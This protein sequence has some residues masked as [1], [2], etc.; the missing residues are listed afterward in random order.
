M[1]RSRLLV[2]H[3]LNKLRQ[4]EHTAIDEEYEKRRI[5]IEEK[6]KNDRLRSSSV[7]KALE[8]CVECKNSEC[9]LKPTGFK[10]FDANHGILVW[11]NANKKNDD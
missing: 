9:N 8:Q 5:A 1:R 4:S 3:G 7:A 11:K 6:H 10:N 2:L